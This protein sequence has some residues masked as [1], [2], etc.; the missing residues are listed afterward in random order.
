M[1]YFLFVGSCNSAV[2]Y[3]GNSNGEGVSAYRFDAETCEIAKLGTYPDVENSTFLSVNPSATRLYTNSEL[4]GKPEGLVTTLSYDKENGTFAHL[5]EQSSRGSITAYNS[6]TEDGKFLL[7]ANYGELQEGPDQSLVVYPILEDGELG[8]PVCTVKNEGCGPNKERQDR[9]HTHFAHQMPNGN[10]VVADLGLDKVF[11]YSLSASGQLSQQRVFD[12]PAGSG[13][14]HVAWSADGRWLFVV[15][16]L[17]SNVATL[18]LTKSPEDALVSICPTV[19]E[20][21]VGKSFCSDIQIAPDGRFLYVGNRGDDTIAV[22]SVA[23]DGTL[24]LIAQ[25]PAGGKTPRNLALTPCGRFLFSA[26]QDSDVITLFARDEKDGMLEKSALAIET[27][28]PMV[29][30]IVAA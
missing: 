26:N 12:M 16:E 1:E 9:S 18:D 25:V 4:P 21:S 23:A 29:V 30:A 17:L 3:F 13:P 19:P 7:V 2:P 5:A 28:T 24:T 8:A 22:L 10:V 15:N 27:G 14:R 6:I 11:E 20:S